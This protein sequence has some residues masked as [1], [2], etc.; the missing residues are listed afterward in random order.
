MKVLYL[1]SLCSVK[2][3][4][5]M[6]KKY[7]STSSHAAQKFNRLLVKGLLENGCNVDALTQRIIVAKDTKDD[8]ICL[9]EK[10]DGVYYKYLPRVRNKNFKIGFKTIMRAFKGN[11]EME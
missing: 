6:F 2:E 1:S 10:E 7:G 11:K 5:R 8:Y 3:Y 9:P 4:E